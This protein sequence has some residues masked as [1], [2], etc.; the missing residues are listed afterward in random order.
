MR[1]YLALALFVAANAFPC[2]AQNSQTLRTCNEKA[3]TQT[4]M[5]ACASN[6][7]ARVESQ[8]DDV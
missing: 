4:E 7:L 2:L 5:N 6:E 8:M 1:K 3:K